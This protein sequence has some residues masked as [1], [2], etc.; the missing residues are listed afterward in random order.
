MPPDIEY[1]LFRVVQECL[2]NIRRHTNSE[3]AKITLTRTDEQVILKVSDNG[4]ALRI[5]ASTNGDGIEAIGVGIPGMRHRLKQLG[6][7]LE[8]DTASDGTT[9]TATVPV[10]WVIYDSNPVS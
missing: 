2:T 7:E 6:G 9:V 3:T 8:V 4:T 1:S 10:K 5:E